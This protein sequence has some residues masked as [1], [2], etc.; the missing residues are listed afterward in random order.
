[1]QAVQ[2][3]IALGLPCSFD[4]PV[5]MLLSV[6]SSLTNQ[7][8]GRNLMA[9]PSHHDLIC[10]QKAISKSQSTTHDYNKNKNFYK[11]T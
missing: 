8:P 11:R 10:I 1:M 2:I 9:A 7:R 5:L 3:T 6:A 4:I